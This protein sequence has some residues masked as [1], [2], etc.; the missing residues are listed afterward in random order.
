MK[1]TKSGPE[2]IA[3]ICETWKGTHFNGKDITEDVVF[4]LNEIERLR[5]VNDKLND[6]AHLVCDENNAWWMISA[7]GVARDPGDQAL[8]KLAQYLDSDEYK[9][10]P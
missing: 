2:R 5:A 7:S 8:K 6:L 9:A 10:A 4:L 1:R 3:L